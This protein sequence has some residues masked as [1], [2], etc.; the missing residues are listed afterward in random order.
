MGEGGV[1]S[2]RRWVWF[3]PGYLVYEL[4]SHRLQGETEAEDDVVRARDPDDA[5]G[6]ED[7]ARLPEPPRGELEVLPD[8]HIERIESLR[9]AL[10][11]RVPLGHGVHA[12]EVL[13]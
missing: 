10:R 4:E 7:V 9:P 12:L 6:L 13:R 1:E 5:L 2:V 3:S 11:F 8:S